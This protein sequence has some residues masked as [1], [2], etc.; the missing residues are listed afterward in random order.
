MLWF[1]LPVVVGVTLVGVAMR[2]S[3][4]G[5]FRLGNQSET[6]RWAVTGVLLI[7]VYVAVTTD[8]ESPMRAFAYVVVTLGFLY[9]L[10]TRKGE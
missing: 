3:R 8:P 4:E 5:G 10:A 9:V 2:S 1:V 6:L 7:G